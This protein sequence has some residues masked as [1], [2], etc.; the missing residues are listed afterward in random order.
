VVLNRV[1]P[2]IGLVMPV[3]FGR[4]VAWV[5]FRSGTRQ[6]P[7]IQEMEREFAVAIEVA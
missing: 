3:S 5:K 1:E 2:G 7:V 4:G 6:V